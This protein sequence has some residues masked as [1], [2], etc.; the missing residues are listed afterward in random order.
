ML[1]KSFA[2]VAPSLRE[3]FSV[4]FSI[5]FVK[6][7]FH[8]PQAKHKALP[9]AL[10]KHRRAMENHNE[11]DLAVAIF[12]LVVAS[13]PRPLRSSAPRVKW[14]LGRYRLHYLLSAFKRSFCQFLELFHQANC[15]RGSKCL[16]AHIGLINANVKKYIRQFSFQPTLPSF[17]PPYQLVI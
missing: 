14:E 1:S 12:I 6:I 7:V 2:S 9:E 15:S 17:N 10:N 13:S 4:L 5:V 11:V 8:L 16:T 3:L